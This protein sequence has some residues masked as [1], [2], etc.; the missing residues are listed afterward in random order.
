MCHFVTA[1][2]PAGAPHVTLD[3]IA[4]RHN[5]QL[6]PQPNPSLSTQIGPERRVFLTTLAPC[7]CGTVIGSAHARARAAPDWHSEARRLRKRGWSAAKVARAL[8]Q[9]QEHAV[10]NDQSYAEASAAECNHWLGLLSE[11]L[12][13][14]VNEFGLLL[15]NYSGPLAEDIVLL[16]RE[17]VPVNAAP[18]TLAQMREDVL[19]V[20]VP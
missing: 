7:D 16:G 2:L 10:G 3:A 5:R 15:H 4:R 17:I 12:K 9:K 13:S 18:E 6:Q 11:A 20:F 1:V 8:A 19:Y 14:V